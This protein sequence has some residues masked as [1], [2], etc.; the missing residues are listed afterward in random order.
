MKKYISLRLCCLFFAGIIGC[1]DDETPGVEEN[2]PPVA[3]AG[4]DLTGTT[5]STVTLDGSASSDVDED[6]LTYLWEI[7]TRPQESNT[8]IANHTAAS[9]TFI[10]DVAGTYTLTLTVSD[11]EH[12]DTDETLVEVEGDPMETVEVSSNID[13][14]EVWEDIFSDPAV[15]DYYVSRN[16]AV[17]AG[18]TI[19]PGVVVHVAEKGIITVESGGTLIAEG[20]EDN[21]ITFTSANEAGE[22]LWGGL[23][24]NSSSTLNALDHTV[25]RFGGGENIVYGGGWRMAALGIS[26]DG[27]LNM[28]NTSISK[29]GADGMFV[30]GKNNL[31]SFENNTFSQN[32]DFPLSLS[33]NQ[34]GGIS[35]S[36]T[37]ADDEASSRRED[38]VRVYDSVLDEE[39]EWSALSGGAIYRFVGDVSVQ[40]ALTIQEGTR[41]EF[42]ENVVFA[43]TSDGVLQAKGAA[44]NPIVFTSSGIDDG[45]NWSGIVIESS[46]VNNELDFA[47]VSYAGSENNVYFQG[48][49]SAAIGVA[50]GGK[51][52]LTNSTVSHSNDYGLVVHENGVLQAFGGNSFHDNAD[53]PL[54][55]A[56]NMLGM[57]DEGTTFENNAEN[58]V[59]VL[60]STLTEDA[61]FTDANS[62]QWKAL[63][64]GASYL[65]LGNVIINESLE[66]A[67]GASLLFAEDVM[68]EIAS[69]GSLKAVGTAENNIRFGSHDPDGGVYWKGLVFNSTS[70]R[71]Q[72]QHIVISHGGN[73]EAVYA[74]GWQK[75]NIGVADGAR[76]SLDNATVSNS[77]GYGI[78]IHP[79]AEATIGEGVSY[80]NN[81]QDNVFNGH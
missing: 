38:V 7:S 74:S 17:N 39:Q 69:G 43:V 3:N 26:E 40:E 51:L 6:E 79:N 59:A 64:S 10:P 57:M 44:N 42:D 16:I 41:M 56:A 21:K 28:T 49:K 50:D 5:G 30:V 36:N 37:F 66:L 29:S 1:T 20:A 18:L 77:R 8:T 62:P 46:S 76:L 65:F 34:L 45:R 54:V 13:E 48:W 73:S 19:Q 80:S 72:L 78:V 35:T 60:R 15:A 14:D 32:K 23:L 31:G 11:G 25:F 71:N 53:Y 4:P 27:K 9:A 24:I 2:N 58:V 61:M 63:G 67:P 33:I 12:S 55:L 47:E 22:V 52:R 81:A 75:T 68:A 70:T